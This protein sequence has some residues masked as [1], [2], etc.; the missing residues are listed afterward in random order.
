MNTPCSLK[1]TLNIQFSAKVLTTYQPLFTRSRIAGWVRAAL[2]AN[3]DLTIRFVDEQES[4]ELNRRYRGKNYSTNVLTF[5]YGR[6]RNH[7][8]GIDLVLCCPVVEH[9]AREQKKPLDAHY[10]HLIVH[11]LLHAQG[12]AHQD[13]EQARTMELMEINILAQLGYPDPYVE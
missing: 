2:F 13:D 1:L 10:A 5:A 8:I 7:L 6:L 4:C 3:A 11:G 12:Y 9:E